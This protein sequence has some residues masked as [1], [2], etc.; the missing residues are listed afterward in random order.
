MKINKNKNFSVVNKTK[1]IGFAEITF[2]DKKI[3]KRRKKILH[4][5]S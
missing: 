5:K 4:I 1:T 2:E 3:E